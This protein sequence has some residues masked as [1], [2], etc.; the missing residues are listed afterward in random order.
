MARALAILL[1]WA[2]LGSPARGDPL[3][4]SK[5]ALLLLRVL[6]Y[7]RNLR[8][9][10]TDE[11]TVVVTYRE[12]D[13]KSVD[14][15]DAIAT[16]LQEAASSFVVGGLPVRVTQVPWR[17]TQDLDARLAALHA[18][19]LYVVASLASEAPAI[20]VASRARSA[21]TFGPSREVV[22]AGLA[23]GLVQRADRAALVV[24][25]AAARAEGADLDSGFL[26]IAEVTGRR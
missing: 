5:Q 3:P 1:L 25:V 19:A 8:P 10:A 17:G 21:L 26:A 12:G 13:A 9:R 11:V 24:N 18:A 4:A 6:A 23:L 7:D 22:A 2:A 15:R 14:E 20:S 16:A